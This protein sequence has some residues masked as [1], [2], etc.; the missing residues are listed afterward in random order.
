MSERPETQRLGEALDALQPHVPEPTLRQWRAD[1]DAVR[2]LERD[3]IAEWERARQ[4]AGSEGPCDPDVRKLL[5]YRHEG[6]VDGL[7]F[8][9]ELLGYDVPLL[10]EHELRRAA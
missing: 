1:L 5:E 2:Q 4:L 3:V 10:A 8:V 9:L 6:Y 7:G